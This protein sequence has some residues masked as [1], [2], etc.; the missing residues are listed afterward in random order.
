LSAALAEIRR[1]GV[2]LSRDEM[3]MG[4]SSVAA[5]ISGPERCVI[6]AVSVVLPSRVGNL[7]TLVP[8]VRAACI[9][10]GRAYRRSNQHL[11]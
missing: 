9:G 2:C 8:A 4:A 1:T 11:V 10:I 6:A 5:P 3:T 7:A